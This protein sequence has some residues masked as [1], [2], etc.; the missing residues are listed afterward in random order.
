MDDLV[1]DRGDRSTWIVGLVHVVV[2]FFMITW[3]KVTIEPNEKI[4]VLM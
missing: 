3:S 2:V 4:D 1:E